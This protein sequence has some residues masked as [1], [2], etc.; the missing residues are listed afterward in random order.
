MLT[1]IIITIRC[2]S[3]PYEL[4]HATT[5]NWLIVSIL[6]MSNRA[7]KECRLKHV[8]SLAQSRALDPRSKPTPESTFGNLKMGNAAQ[9]VCP[10]TLIENIKIAQGIPLQSRCPDFK[11]QLISVFH[12][13]QRTKSPSLDP[14]LSVLSTFGNAQNSTILY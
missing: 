5:I 11:S 9:R 8:M 12:V 14:Y 10:L 13:W 1:K 3:P 7:D 6:P 2:I 4:K